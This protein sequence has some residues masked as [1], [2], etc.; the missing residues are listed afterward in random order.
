[1]NLSWRINVSRQSSRVDWARFVAIQGETA[2]IDHGAIGHKTTNKGEE[3]SLRSFC[4]KSTGRDPN[5][6]NHP[7]PGAQPGG[8]FGAFAPPEIFKTLHINF[9]I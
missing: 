6:S 5:E 7:R 4:G 3:R 8:A 1:L 9:D 2:H